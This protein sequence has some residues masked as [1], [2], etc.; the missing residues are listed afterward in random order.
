MQE[1]E[2]LR[3]GIQKTNSKG[4]LFP[5]MAGFGLKH[6]FGEKTPSRASTDSP[7]MFLRAD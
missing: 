6:G 4:L 1:A 5:G 2:L 7:Y 3:E